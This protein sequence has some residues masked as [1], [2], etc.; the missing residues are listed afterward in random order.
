MEDIK[1]NFLERRRQ[2]FLMEGFYKT[3]E[4]ETFEIRRPITARELAD[5]KLSP[6]G[7]KYMLEGHASET[8]H[9]LHL[10]YTAGEPIEKLRSDLDEVVAAWEDFAKVQREFKGDE[11]WSAFRFSYRTDYNDIVQLVGVA[12]LMRREDLIPRI[13]ELC[14][15]YRRDDSIYDALTEPFLP[16]AEESDKYTWFHDDPYAL[17]VDVLDSD[18]PNEQSALMKEAVERWYAANEGLPFHGTHKDI[19]DEGHGGY[20]GYWCFELAALCYLKNIDDSRFRNH[21]TYPKDLVDFARAYRAEPDRQPPPTSG[22]ATFQVLS[23]RPGEPCPREGVW[24]AVHLRGKEIRMRQGETMPGPK[25][26]P[27]GAVTW[28]FKGP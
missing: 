11:E 4:R 6:L 14:H 2:P 12:I 21:L 23:A 25:I 22:A 8:T 26:G 15:I 1:T 27:S 20:F 9:L 7:R 3:W 19:D 24:F 18:D 13:H 16:P 17:V 5:P 28:Y 10:R